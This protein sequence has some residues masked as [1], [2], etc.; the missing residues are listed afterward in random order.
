MSEQNVE[1]ARRVVEAFNGR[2]WEG[3]A[4]WLDH[5][6]EWEPAGPAAVESPLYRGRD[7]VS[8]GFASAWETWEVFRIEEREVRELE[9]AVLWLGSARMRGG[10]SHVEF[11]Q[12]FAVHFLFRGGKIVRFRGF[13]EWQEAL[14]A[15][16]LKTPKKSA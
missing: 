5:E 16:G 1:V 2:D 11:E 13:L 3:M 7:E 15:A 6:V 10:A 14:E 4:E 8:R 9:D 12:A